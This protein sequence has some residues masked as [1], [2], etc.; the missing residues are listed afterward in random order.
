MGVTP[1]AKT[2]F[3]VL[4]GRLVK[5]KVVLVGG[6]S[7]AVALKRL[8]RDEDTGSW[9]IV[10]SRVISSLRDEAADVDRRLLA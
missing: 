10:S 7:T 9:F 8:L 1:G 5:E 3:I 2:F 4:W 6:L